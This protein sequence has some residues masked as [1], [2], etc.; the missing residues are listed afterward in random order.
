[1]KK[2]LQ[3]WVYLL[4]SFGSLWAQA[5]GSKLE[6]KYISSE[7]VYVNAGRL[8]GANVGSKYAVF[9]RNTKI[10]D[11]RVIYV[12][13]HSSACKI[14]TK[15][16]NLKVGDTVILLTK[17]A[18]KKIKIQKEQKSR[19]TVRR[20][21]KTGSVR[22]MHKA[23]VSGN[24]SFQWYHI[25]DLSSSHFNFDQPGMRLNFKIRNMF[26]KDYNFRVKTRSRYNKRVRRFSSD[27]P[28]DEWRNRIYT[29]SFSYDNKNA[30]FN[31]RIGRIISN[32]MSGIGYIDGILLQQNL[33]SHFRYG[34]FGGTQPEWHYSNYQAS[35]QKYGAYLNF[36]K[37][38]FQHRRYEGTI[39]AAGEYHGSTVSRE[40]L[41]FQN[42]Y[43]SG[44]LNV[45]Q[46]AELDLNRK[47]RKEK[48]GQDVSLTNLYIT[49][50]YRIARNVTAGMSY[51]NRKN[52][53]TYEIRSVA[54]S[55]FDDAMRYGLR[56][57]INLRLPMQMNF[58]ANFGMRKRS[59]D[60]QNTF[61]YAAGMNKSNLSPQRLFVSL[62]AS[63]FSNYY[64]NG[65]H[66]SARLG[67]HFRA[68]HSLSVSFGNYYYSLKSSNSSRLN[69]WV[70]VNATLQFFKHLYFLEN[71]EYVWGADA[72]GHR[73]F[74]EIGYRF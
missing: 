64:A 65:Y 24:V 2:K 12:G 14:M 22:S 13:D 62:F 66:F 31:Y 11:L 52:Y 53:Y 54:D 16:M 3:L 57:N 48:S 29:V 35:L 1:M 27:I 69:Q 18:I 68:G 17:A 44:P 32:E 23:R 43:F 38:T 33:T 61:S 25:E 19:K 73:I 20:T 28:K 50:S 58:F 45:Y 26:N 34:L 30:L 42:N 51:D 15:T 70:R 6:I 72:P 8:E 9:R 46:S 63:G 10:A 71:Y 5:P 4:I 55:L 41:Y 47:W 21:K 37:G 39:A 59:A 49:S 74:T 56:G 7:N 67:K 60:K 36:S 40:F